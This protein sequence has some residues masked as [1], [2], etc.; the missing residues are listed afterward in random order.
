M[1]GKGKPQ[2]MVSGSLSDGNDISSDSVAKLAMARKVRYMHAFYITRVLFIPS[3]ALP[4][5]STPC[6]VHSLCL[7][8]ITLHLRLC[9]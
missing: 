1:S 8:L 9:R 3:G 6:V 7:I 2:R 5:V 4:G